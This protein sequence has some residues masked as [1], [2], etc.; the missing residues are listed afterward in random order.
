[1]EK[2]TGQ[3][4]G[5]STFHAT[6]V[7]ELLAQMQKYV[8]EHAVKGDQGV[9]IAAIETQGYEET[10]PDYTTTKIKI[11]K[12]DG[13]VE[14]IEISARHGQNG[15]DGTNGKDGDQGV[16]IAAIKTQGYEETSPDYTTT[17]IKITKTDGTSS[18]WTAFAR[19]GADGK[20]GFWNKFENYI[21]RIAMYESKAELQ[22][23]LNNSYDNI[24]AINGSICADLDIIPAGDNDYRR[25]VFTGNLSI[26]KMSMNIAHIILNLSIVPENL[27]NSEGIYVVSMIDPEIIVGPSDSSFLRIPLRIF[28]RYGNKLDESAFTSTFNDYTA[29]L[30]VELFE[31]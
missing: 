11:T 1:M 19:H 12:T 27:T 6:T 15:A 14:N 13:T 24:K 3:E 16:G 7:T 28:D 25:F 21:C 22:I 5:I 20:N 10:S 9:G 26:I 30:S 31:E 4:A 23:Q 2:R 18:V 29:L 17:K 8:I